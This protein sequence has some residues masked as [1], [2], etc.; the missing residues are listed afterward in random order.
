[1]ATMTDTLARPPAPAGDPMLPAP[2]R[3]LRRRQETHDTFTVALESAGAGLSFWFAPGQYNM[4]YTFG[5]GEVPISMSGPPGPTREIIHTIRAVGPVTQ[6]L[7]RLRPGD[8]VGLRGPF[9]I[10]WPVEQAEGRD[11]VIVAGGVGLAPV[12]PAIYHVLAHREKYGRVTFL[13]GA[14]TPEDLL[15]AREIE[16]WRGRFDVD[17]EVTVDRAH[18]GWHGRVGVVTTLI[19]RAHFDPDAATAFICGPEVMMSF[20]TR[21]LVRVG[22]ERESMFVSLERNM[23]CAIGLCGHCQLGPIFVCKDGPVFRY[24]RVATLLGMREL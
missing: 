11:V 15:F 21:E 17:A 13:I 6:A 2:F 9:G 1:M 8:I 7:G 10:P 19:P 23:K 22:V 4:L 18:H 12:R 20:A 3:V 16:E 24:D 5:A 14:R